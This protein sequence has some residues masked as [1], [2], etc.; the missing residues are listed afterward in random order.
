[1]EDFYMEVLFGIPAHTAAVDVRRTAAGLYAT[2]QRIAKKGSV[3]RNNSFQPVTKNELVVHLRPL[4]SKPAVLPVRLHRTIP[5]SN[6]MINIY[7][8]SRVPWVQNEV[9]PAQFLGRST[10]QQV[11]PRNV[12]QTKNSFVTAQ[13][14]TIQWPD[15]LRRT[16]RE[17]NEPDLSRRTGRENNEPDLSRRTGRENNEPDLS[18]RTGR[19]NNEPDLSRRTGR[20]N[21]EPKPPALEYIPLTPDQYRRTYKCFTCDIDFTS[22]NAHRLHTQKV[23]HNTTIQCRYCSF[24]CTKHYQLSPHNKACHSTQ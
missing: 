17:N 7:E 23:G 13:G 15:L 6:T 19:E 11:L 24:T 10:L 16:G 4:P 3:L 5:T 9:Q 2:Q 21:N 12:T 8:D 20:E 22:M 18:R 1:M 14:T